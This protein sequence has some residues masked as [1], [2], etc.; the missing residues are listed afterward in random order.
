MVA[1]EVKMT[2]GVRLV[3]A[4]E[5]LGIHPESLKRKQNY[6]E[7]PD[8]A[9]QKVGRILLFNLELLRPLREAE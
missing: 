4:A 1:P 9:C 6:G 8:G 2:N 7:L 3:E 5:F